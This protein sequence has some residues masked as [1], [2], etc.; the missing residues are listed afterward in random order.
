MEHDVGSDSLYLDVVEI[1][2]G[3]KLPYGSI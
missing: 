2:T 3:K 1:V